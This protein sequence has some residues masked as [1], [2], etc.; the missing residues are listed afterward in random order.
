MR[1][2]ANRGLSSAAL[3][4][5]VA[6][7][8]PRVASGMAIEAAWATAHL[9]MYPFGL[10]S[11]STRAVADR[12][13]HDLRGLSPEQRGLFHHRVDAAE[14]PIVLVHGIIDNHAIFTV[15]EYVLRRRGFQTLSTYDYGLLTDNIPRAAARLGEA[16]RK[17]VV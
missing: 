12:R 14:T 6:L 13:R 3:S 9:V 5:L 15:M 4:R 16:D 10:L 2:S 7:D 1:A 11:T 8:M 17:S